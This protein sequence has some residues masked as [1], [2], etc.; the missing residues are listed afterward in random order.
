MLPF[1]FML[2]I[3]SK[4]F[5]LVATNIL[6]LSGSS[7]HMILSP[8]EKDYLYES[9]RLSPPV[10]PDSRL[11]FQYRPLEATV[12][13]LPSSNG[14]ARMR[15]VDGSECIVSVKSK[16]VSISEEPNLISCD[17]SV[18]GHRDDSNF[19]SNLRFDITNS[20]VVNFPYEILKLTSKYSF[21][22]YIDCIVISHTS[23]PLSLI[24]FTCY[25]AL[26][27]TKLPKLISEVNDETIEEQPTFSDDWE[28]AQSLE[29]LH[30]SG[31]FQ[32]PIFITIGTVGDN[33][34][35]DPSL[36]EEQVLENGMILTWYKNKVITPFIN[37]HLGSNT[38]NVNSKGLNAPL[39]T[40]S[41]KLVEKYSN[42]INLALDRLIDQ[43][44]IFTG[45]IY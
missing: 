33:L 26:K 42:Q 3:Y 44:E 43:E 21:K 23:Y 32:P 14:S 40:K 45:K 11:V 24:S 34:Y 18:S 2:F 27:T 25:L 28:S 1:F 22:L 37:T 35:F 39:L 9:L 29:A 16:V 13:F 15:L 6:L 38:T 41:L 12:S 19:V 4:A 10:R 30:K 36:E 20:L 31:L 8:A 7:V 5:F 17:V